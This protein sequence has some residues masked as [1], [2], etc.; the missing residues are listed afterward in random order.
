MAAPGLNSGLSHTQAHATSSTSCS[1]WAGRR[2]SCA[3]HLQGHTCPE[4]HLVL[5]CKTDAG[6]HQQVQ[7][8]VWLHRGLCCGHSHESPFSLFGIPAELNRQ[9]GS[10][11]DFQRWLQ[12]HLGAQAPSQQVFLGGSDTINTQP[13]KR[14]DNGQ[15]GAGNG[16][17]KW[18]SGDLDSTFPLWPDPGEVTWYLGASFSPSEKWKG[19]DNHQSSQLNTSV[20]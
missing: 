7:W 12:D 20:I 3:G 18:V 10:S 15:C 17:V 8:K 9:K 13:R 2:V 5:S 19:L 16:S 14:P 1:L 11:T 4:L 6:H